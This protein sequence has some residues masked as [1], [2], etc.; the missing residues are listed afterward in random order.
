[1]LMITDRAIQE[2]L[3]RLGGNIPCEVCRGRGNIRTNRI[4]LSKAYDIVFKCNE[5]NGYGWFNKAKQ[6]VDIE[7]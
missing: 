6:R 4:V 5:C 1:M 3:A 7:P 2:A